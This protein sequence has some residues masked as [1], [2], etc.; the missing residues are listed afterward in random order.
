[1]RNKLL[2]GFASLLLMAASTSTKATVV[3]LYDNFP[4]NQGDNGFFVYGYNGTLHPLSDA[5][6]YAFN[7]PG[8]Q[9]SNPNVFKEVGSW[10]GAPWIFMGPA[11]TR[12]ALGADDAILAYKAPLTATYRLDGAFYLYPQSYNGAYAMILDANLGAIWQS[13]LGPGTQTDF[14]NVTLS[15][16]A[17][18]MLYFL[19]DAYNDMDFSEYDDWTHL[20][21]TITYDSGTAPE[22]GTVPEPSSLALL[23][24][25]GLGLIAARRRKSA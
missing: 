17:G 7:R 23:G 9:W 5:G 8:D 3:D 24:V 19:T 6:P 4:D 25:T 10:L 16:N 18:Q 20:R 22:P 14:N 11:G 13:Y 12:S 21:G 15:L 1:M 2:T